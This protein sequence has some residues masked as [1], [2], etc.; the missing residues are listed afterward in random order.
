MQLTV[1]KDRS[2]QFLYNCPKFPAY[3]GHGRTSSFP[4]HTALSHWHDDIEFCIVLSGRMSYNVNGGDIR[5]DEG[6][7]IFINTRQMHRNFSDDRKDCEY[8]CILLH[9]MLLCASQYVEETFVRPVLENGAFSY[10]VLQ[11]DCEWARR[12]CG[13]LREMYGRHEAPGSQLAVQSGFFQ[14]WEELYKN[15]PIEQKASKPRSQNLNALKDMI[16][17]IQNN[18]QSRVTLEDISR[19]GNMGKTSCSKIF[20]RY[21]NQSPSAY[22]IEYRLRNGAELLRT[23][24]MTVAEICYEVGFGGP[25][26][27]SESFRKVFGCTPLEYRS[28]RG[29]S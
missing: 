2:E 11:K 7:G 26:Y 12:V 15:A 1:R 27:F 28:G 19:A 24:D 9:P 6:D 20:Q 23:T 5:L 14:I 8:L 3:F 4:N 22:L 21:V 13:K 25:S 10:Q 17:Y 29:K 16:A 18:Y